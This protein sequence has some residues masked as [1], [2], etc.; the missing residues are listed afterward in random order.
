ME[1][2]NLTAPENKYKA[3]FDFE[4]TGLHQHTTPIS[5]GI[6]YASGHQLYAEFTDYDRSQVNDWIQMHVIDN[7]TL[8]D[9]GPNT[10]RFSHDNLRSWEIRGT[11]EYVAQEIDFWHQY[12]YP[13]YNNTKIEMWSDVL[14]YDWMLF[15]QMYGHAFNIPK[16]IYY[17]PF[18]IATLMKVKGVDPDIS[19]EELSGITD[20]GNQK[21]NAL[22]DAKIIQA[23]YD[24]LIKM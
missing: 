18:D 14:A 1:G 22:W 15:N 4:F 17:I 19:R 12:I 6:T 20:I 9:M 11:R 10:C 24:K 23:C 16:N 8:G 2:F 13:D 21:H 3:F 5:I 7:L